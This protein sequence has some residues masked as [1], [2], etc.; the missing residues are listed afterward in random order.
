MQTA[1]AEAVFAIYNPT[2]LQLQAFTRLNG[3]RAKV[4]YQI[5]ALVTSLYGEG[6]YPVYALPGGRWAWDSTFY[7]CEAEFEGECLRLRAWPLSPVAASYALPPSVSKLMQPTGARRPG[8]Q[9]GGY[10]RPTEALRA[11]VHGRIL[12]IPEAAQRYRIHKDTLRWRMQHHGVT[13]EQAVDMGPPGVGGRKKGTGSREQGEPVGTHLIRLACGQPPE[14]YARPVAAPEG[15]GMA[16]EA[17]EPVGTPCMASADHPQTPAESAEPVG[18]MSSSPADSPEPRR[19]GVAPPA[20]SPKRRRR[21]KPKPAAPDDYEHMTIREAAL[22][23]G[24]KRNT[25]CNRMYKHRLTLRQAVEMGPPVRG[26]ARASARREPVHGE[27][28]TVHQAALRYGIN[29]KTV[30][31]RLKKPGVTLEQAVEAPLQ[32]RGRGNRD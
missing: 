13:L 21:A 20:P 23:T 30:R 11:P 31:S 3:R 15:E 2:E 5:V 27:V 22:R 29:E 9:P 7:H 28:M 10:S 16:S 19:G 24:I 18:A 8:G 1:Q 6:G 14:R 12:S 17:T 25:L 26:G 4:P 32:R